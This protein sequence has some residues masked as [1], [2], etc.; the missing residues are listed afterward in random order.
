MYII[1]FEQLRM[2]NMQTKSAIEIVAV[3]SKSG[4]FFS[5]TVRVSFNLSYFNNLFLLRN[6]GEF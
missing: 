4:F 6:G 3:L 5:I 2:I 1:S